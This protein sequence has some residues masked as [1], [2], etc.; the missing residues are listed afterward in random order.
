[1]PGANDVLIAFAGMGRESAAGETRRVLALFPRP[2]VVVTVGI[3]GGLRDGLGVADVV[4]PAE[5]VADF[6]E[7]GVSATRNF[8]EQNRE[9]PY[10]SGRF[11]TRGKQAQ[12]QRE[13]EEKYFSPE[14]LEKYARSQG[15]PAAPGL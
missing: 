14:V 2:G 9:N 6:M 3:C 5:V 15:R 1:M 13:L 12:K 10:V 8:R 7:H 11:K 4:V